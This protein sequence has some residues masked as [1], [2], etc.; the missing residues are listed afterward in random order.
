MPGASVGEHAD[1]G[2]S[3][4]QTHRCHVA[5]VTNPEVRFVI[6]GSSYY[7]EPGEAYEVDNMRLHSVSN[8]TGQRRVHLICNILPAEWSPAAAQRT[9]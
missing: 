5:V 3:L 2:I 9:A 1:E 8:P 4:E 6:E 7:L